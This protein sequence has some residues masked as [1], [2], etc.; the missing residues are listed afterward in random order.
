[1]K[2]TISDEFLDF[3]GEYVTKLHDDAIE[4]E[5]AAK[6]PDAIEVKLPVNKDNVVS[7]EK[8]RL[9]QSKTLKAT[10][11]YLA[12]TFGPMGSNTKIVTGTNQAEIT[13]SYSK[14]GL[15]VLSNIINSAP[16]EASIVDELISLTKAVEGEVGDGTTS[17]VILSSIIFDRLMNIEKIYDVP[18]FK[19]SR[20]FQKVV[21]QIK[22]MILEDKKECTIDDIRDIAM[23]STNGNEE[24]ADNIQTVYKQYGMDVDINVG[25]SNNSDTMVKVYDGLTITEGMSDPAFIN[26]KRDNTSEIHDAHVY[27]FA[28]PVDTMDQ[29]VLFESILKHNIYD[30][31]EMGEEMIPTVITCPRFSVDMSSIMKKLIEQLYRFDSADQQ[32]AKPPILI[33]T[34][35]IASDEAIMDDI[36][37]LCGCKSIHKYI[38][39]NVYQRDVETGLAATPE[40][41]HEFYGKA[42]LV[43]ADAKKTKF[44]NPMHMLDE[45]DTVYQSM[46]N[47]LETEIANT[48]GSD[49]AHSIGLLKKRLSA[50]KANMV[51]FLVGGVTIAQRDMQKDLVED[52]VKNCKSASR[53]G[54]GYAANFMGLSKSV[55]LAREYEGD[56]PLEEAIIYS[57][58]SAYIDISRVLYNTVAYDHQDVT[59]NI[60]RSIDNGYPY[61]ISSGALP[62]SLDDE[63]GKKVLCTIKLDVE[64]LEAISKIITMMV[65]SNQCLLMSSNVNLY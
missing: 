43:V 16:I 55:V 65:T 14:D 19:I 39:P 51:D 37:N 18:P 45:N 44:I 2:Q 1:M 13:S 46:I 52:A 41:V 53:D 50:L 63:G 4:A 25:I 56:D 64:I 12:K 11:E 24:I 23:I 42:E 32:S 38:D 36:A 35:V 6:D 5:E 59:A 61:D 31:L 49:D 17:T 9:V 21:N 48:K 28:D 40:T 58:A 26:N 30:P 22:E 60:Y 8:L 27:H 34:N 7:G 54:V 57:I 10:A 29:I 33:V 20:T 47:F 3:I 62:K 15:K